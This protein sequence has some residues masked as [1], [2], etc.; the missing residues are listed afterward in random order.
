[1]ERHQSRASLAAVSGPGAAANSCPITWV[2]PPPRWLRSN[3]FDQISFR[4]TQQLTGGV[5]RI[6]DAPFRAVGI[7]VEHGPNEGL[8]P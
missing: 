3:S 2:P 4:Q 7:L 8:E 1:M 5:V 6:T